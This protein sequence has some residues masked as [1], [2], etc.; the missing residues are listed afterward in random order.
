MTRGRGGPRATTLADGTVF[1]LGNEAQ[2]GS[3]VG[4]ARTDSVTVE[5]RDPK[6]GRWRTGASLNSP[7]GRAAVVALA[8]GRVLVAGGENAGDGGY[9][10]AD[11]YSSAYVY[12]PAKDT[13]TK[14]GLMH[15]ARTDAAAA[16][17]K[18][19][20]VLIAGGYFRTHDSASLLP[21]LASY[22]G[23]DPATPLDPTDVDVPPVGYA[24]ATAE[25]WDPAT[26][27]WSRTGS[28]S[29]ARYGAGVTM[30][31]DGRV[32]VAGSLSED[33]TT[34]TLASSTAEIYDLATGRF[35]LTRSLPEPDWPKLSKTLGFDLSPGPGQAMRTGALVALPGGNALLAGQYLAWKHEASLTRSL[36]YDASADRWLET[37]FTYLGAR[38]EYPSARH[39]E[40][41]TAPL[42]GVSAVALRSGQVL[43]VGS[44]P[45]GRV[46]GFSGPDDAPGQL[47]D[48]GPVQL[49]D[50]ATDR[51]RSLAS[52]PAGRT[53]GAL[54]ALR[55]G[56]L[57]A[58]GGT[59][60]NSSW[61]D[62]A[63]PW[64]LRSTLRFVP[65]R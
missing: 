20:R 27:E 47:S 9:W 57:L 64:G 55:D 2:S 4:A 63:T 50:A 43:I 54:V 6:T 34:P 51:W 28:L 3:Y 12:D 16:L 1:V 52:L 29:F 14:T 49:Y 38:D 31:S 60:A 21:A 25:I 18:D 56:S 46:E 42:V 17:L 7:R 5:L 8:D 30:L 33:A 26:G 10:S 59:D 65:T 44:P 24:L 15:Q 23:G 45:S 37:G 61:P 53:I 13:W 48:R 11:S 35:K 19:G 22:V 40:T 41:G 32:M 39:A 58:I 62:P 36:R